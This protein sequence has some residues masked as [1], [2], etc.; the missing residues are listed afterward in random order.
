[1]ELRVGVIGVVVEVTPHVPSEAPVVEARCLQRVEAAAVVTGLGRVAKARALHP[2]DQGG[3]G[4]RPDI[5]R[6]HQ[7]PIAAGPHP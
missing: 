3:A 7:R 4:G 6:V 1:M 5:H 2:P